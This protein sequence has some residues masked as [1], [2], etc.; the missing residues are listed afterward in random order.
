MKLPLLALSIALACASVALADSLPHKTV[1]QYAAEK[2]LKVGHSY[3]WTVH[4]RPAND[5]FVIKNKRPDKVVKLA[6]GRALRPRVMLKSEVD[7][8]NAFLKGRTVLPRT[9]LPSA[10]LSKQKPQVTQ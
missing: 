7:T 8:H 9:A 6:A 1:A 4:P 2:H 3:L 5:P 10:K